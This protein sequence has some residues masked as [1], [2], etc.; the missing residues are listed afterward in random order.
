MKNLFSRIAIIVAIC[1]IASTT[2]LAATTTRNVTFTRTVTVNGTPVKA[3][4]YKVTFDDQTGA[5]T[6]LDGK[7]IVAKAT[8]RLEKVKGTYQGAYSMGTVNNDLVSMN[9]NSNSQAV[10]VND[11]V[12]TEKLT[13]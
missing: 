8:A 3:G 10:I 5:F 2:A 13:P 1:A 11:G 9:M 4:T 6:I 12:M 7:K